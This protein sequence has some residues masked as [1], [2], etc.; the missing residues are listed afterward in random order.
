VLLGESL[1]IRACRFA[2]AHCQGRDA[3]ASY[4]IAQTLAAQMKKIPGVVDVRIP[5]EFDYPTLMVDVDRSKAMQLGLSEEGAAQSLLDSLASSVE[6]SPN[7]WLDSDSSF[8]RGPCCP[9]RPWD[10]VRSSFPARC[11]F[12]GAG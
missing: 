8:E 7:N 9:M 10:E 6:V 3:A 11:P 4:S 12:P 2:I 5:Q 1:E